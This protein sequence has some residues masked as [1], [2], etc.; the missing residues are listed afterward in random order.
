[1]A[2]SLIYGLFINIL[3]VE[4]CLAIITGS[5]CDC[6][7]YDISCNMIFHYSA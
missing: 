4:D 1:V 7:E 6:M 5:L 2:Y 3:T